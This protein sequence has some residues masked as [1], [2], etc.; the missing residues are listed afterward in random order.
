MLAEIKDMTV[1]VREEYVVVQD[2][3]PVAKALYM[4]DKNIT[5]TV[6]QRVMT[7]SLLP[8]C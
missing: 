3:L 7:Y 2:R 1:T 4:K 8:L 5:M 6:I